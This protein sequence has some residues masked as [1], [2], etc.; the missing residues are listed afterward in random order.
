[1]IVSCGFLSVALTKMKR[2]KM[3]SHFVPDRIVVIYSV[4]YILFVSSIFVSAL[5]RW[6]HKYD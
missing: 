6:L 1:M 2:L 5:F 4:A 3:A